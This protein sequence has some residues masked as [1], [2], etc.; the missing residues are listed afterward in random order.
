MTGGRKH[1]FDEDVKW[2]NG[3]DE[4]SGEQCVMSGAGGS[5]DAESRLVTEVIG[6]CKISFEYQVQTYEGCF[7]VTCGGVE[8]L[9]FIGVSNPGSPW[10]QL[11]FDVPCGKH[12]IV[13]SYRHPERG[14]C[15]LFNG[16]RIKKFKVSQC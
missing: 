12:K 9:C 10:Q 13:I 14:F 4:I 3:V 1:W 11:A 16:A 8:S 2:K 6:P 5:G 7:R 15:N